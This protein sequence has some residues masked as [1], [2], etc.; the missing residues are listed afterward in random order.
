MSEPRLLLEELLGQF[1]DAVLRVTGRC[2]EPRIREGERVRLRSARDCPPRFGDVV[3]TWQSGGLRLHRLVWALG[4]RVRT[5]ADRGLL[6]ASLGRREILA[7]VIGVE[8]RPRPLDRRLAARS[9]LRALTRALSSRF[10]AA[11]AA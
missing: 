2:L 5:Q 8:D 6:D 10:A 7:T 11:L 9:L 1:P 4:D 3:L